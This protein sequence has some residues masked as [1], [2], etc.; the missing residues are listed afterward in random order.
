MI[1]KAPKP[2]FSPKGDL[3]NW[4]EIETFHRL[5]SPTWNKV[6]WYSQNHRYGELIRLRV[7]CAM[8]SHEV[9]H[10]R[11]IAH[12]AAVANPSLIIEP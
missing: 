7:L 2:E 11:D 5:N 10:Y 3:L 1:P 4:I 12:R 9:E 6:F 8:L